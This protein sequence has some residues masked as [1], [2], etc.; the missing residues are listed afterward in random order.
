MIKYPGVKSV[1]CGEAG[2]HS[3]L[4]LVCGKIYY[5]ITCI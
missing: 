3:K 4:K 1:I 5:K 2:Q